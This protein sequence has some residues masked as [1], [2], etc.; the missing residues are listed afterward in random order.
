VQPARQLVALTLPPELVTQLDEIAAAEER[1]RVKVIEFAC[2]EYVQRAD[3][4]RP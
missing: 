4:G 1:S 2:R 3:G